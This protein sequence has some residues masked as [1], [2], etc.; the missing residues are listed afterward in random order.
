MIYFSFIFKTKKTREKVLAFL[1][2]LGRAYNTNG[3]FLTVD[4]KTAYDIKNYL[5]SRK[6]KYI[7]FQR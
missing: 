7:V 6:L 4:I 3:K 2:D 5:D 1:I